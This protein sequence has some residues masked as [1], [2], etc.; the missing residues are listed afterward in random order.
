MRCLAR[1]YQIVHCPH[2]RFCHAHFLP[3]LACP[4]ERNMFKYISIMPYPRRKGRTPVTVIARLAPDAARALVPSL[5]A[6]L[7]EAVA[8]GASVGFL[9]PLTDADA[10][11][12]WEGVVAGVAAS[13]RVLLVAYDGDNDTLAG[14]VQLELAMRANGSHRAEVQRLLV[15]VAARRGGVGTALMHAAEDAARDHGRTLLVLDT[16]TG[17]AAESL[18]TKL[19]YTRVG[20]IPRYARSAAGTL[21]ATVYFYKEI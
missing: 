7:Q 9:P 8:G 2:R 21:D 6:L 16:R 4:M 5:A 3:G 12:Y 13:E 1:V 10:T 19:G 15:A 11:A 20:V 18:Y 14:T 17:D